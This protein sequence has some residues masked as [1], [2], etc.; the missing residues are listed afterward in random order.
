V[1]GVGCRAFVNEDLDVVLK[2]LK[3]R[4]FCSEKLGYSVQGFSSQL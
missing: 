2:V 1:D 3:V 4:P